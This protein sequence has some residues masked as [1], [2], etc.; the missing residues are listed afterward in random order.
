M[1]KILRKR[2][3][4]L[5][6]FTIAMEKRYLI[7]Q[8]KTYRRFEVIRSLDTFYAACSGVSCRCVWCP[9]GQNESYNQ[10]VKNCS[11]TAS[12]VLS[13]FFFFFSLFSFSL[14]KP[15][16]SDFR[17]VLSENKYFVSYILV[18]IYYNMLNIIV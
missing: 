6:P 9:V 1:N 14:W 18:G 12:E 16:K 11:M 13:H 15:Y 17:I 5:L 10:K 3:D 4:I 7:I 2:K 8:D